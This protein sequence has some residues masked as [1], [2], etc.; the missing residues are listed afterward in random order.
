LVL[1]SAG[2]PT[3][4]LEKWRDVQAVRPVTGVLG[5]DVHQNVSIKPLCR[6]AT[7]M[8]LCQIAAAAFPNVLT[9]LAAGG[10]VGLADGERIDS[11]ARVMRWLNNRVLVPEVSVSATLDA[12]RRGRNYGLFAVFGEP[13]T[14][15]YFADTSSG[16]VEMGGTIALA[17]STLRVR[18]PDAPAPE[19]GAT[20]TASDAA[21]AELRAVLWRTTVSGTVA[22]AEWRDFSRE[23]SMS[24]PGPGAYWL[25]VWLT[26]R[27]LEAALGRASAL[28]GFEYRWIL[29]NP[30]FVE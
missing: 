13:G 26:P 14:F 19:L 15:A 29:T 7:A 6:G 28:A 9:A 30:I 22:A 21:R 23:V 16:R 1:L 2:F 12:L 5:S 4:G 18:L 24:L 10:V 25:E 3:E 17:G 8:A 27:H 11:Y 20:W